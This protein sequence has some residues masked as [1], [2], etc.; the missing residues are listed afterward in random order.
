MFTVV[1]RSFRTKMQTDI[2][3]PLQSGNIATNYAKTVVGMTAGVVEEERQGRALCV[4]FK[5]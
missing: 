2:I 1:L 5:S 4:A 3:S